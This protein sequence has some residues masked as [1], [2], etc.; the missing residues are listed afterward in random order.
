MKRVMHILNYFAVLTIM[1]A[2]SQ[3]TKVEVPEP[4]EG[5]KDGASNDAVEPTAGPENLEQ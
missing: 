4:V 1:V 2:C 3:Q 5:P